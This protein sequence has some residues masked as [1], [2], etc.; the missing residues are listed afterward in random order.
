M[1]NNYKYSVTERL[2]QYVQID[3]QSDSSSTTHPST[4]KQKNLSTLLA[5]Q[6]LDLGLADAHADEYG[7]VYAT[8]PATST[9]QI[10]TICFCSHVDTTSDCSG[11]NVLPIL[12]HNY[13]GTPIVL[14]HDTTQVLSTSK[15]P[16]LLNHIGNT[17][18]TASG[19]T[20]LGADDKAGV[21]I[22]MDMVQYLTTHLEVQHG[23][24]KILF[25]PDEEIGKGTAKINME[26]LQADYGY[27][28]DG[29]AAGSLED[30]TFSANAAILTIQG[31]SAHP[32]DAKGKMANALKIASD[33]IQAIPI[34]LS[35][36]GTSHKQGFIHPLHIEGIAEK[37]TIQFIIRDFDTTQLAVKETWIRHTTEQ[38]I[39][40]YV[41]ATYT[42]EVVEQYSNMKDVLKDC[43]HVVNY[44]K[45]AIERTGL[46]VIMDSIR[47]GTDGSKLSYIG[48]PCPN[49]YTGMQNI[50]SKLEWVGVKDMQLA[51][52]TLVHLVMIWEEH[53]E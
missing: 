2:L 25:T 21:A 14:P 29:G 37:A 31:V 9:K 32:G 22:I 11:T 34:N 52:S 49:I 45:E 40:K 7:Y 3:T 24:I 17:I 48:L 53:G 28:L 8:I 18:I 50:H 35:P 44:A 23:T 5:Q 26:K 47:G 19:T 6:L 41:G 38:V 15:Y 12:H 42:L 30:E 27:T 36:E 39:T 51:V 10:P 13:D 33:I 46:T 43:Y 16:Y 4:A 1:D 20:L